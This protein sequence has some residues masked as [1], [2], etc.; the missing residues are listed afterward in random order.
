[1]QTLQMLQMLQ[2]LQRF[3][4]KGGRSGMAIFLLLFEFYPLD[5]SAKLLQTIFDYKVT[6]SFISGT[7]FCEEPFSAPHNLSSGFKNP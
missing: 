2:M 1:M 6:T 3:Q 5:D 7:H 4:Q